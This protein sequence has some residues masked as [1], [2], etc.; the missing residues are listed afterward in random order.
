MEPHHSNE[1]RSRMN[2]EAYSYFIPVPNVTE[3]T[4]NDYDRK[5]LGDGWR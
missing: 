3:T 2:T 1:Q 4:W 5:F